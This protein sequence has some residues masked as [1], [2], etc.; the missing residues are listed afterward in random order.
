[1]DAL[2]DGA[3]HEHPHDDAGCQDQGDLPDSRPIEPETPSPPR[4][5]S[6]PT[7]KKTDRVDRITAG[8]SRWNN[9][10]IEGPPMEVA[11]PV[12]PAPN[13]ELTRV[14]GVT[15]SGPRLRRSPP[16]RGSSAARAMPICSSANRV[17]SHAPTT[18]PGIRPGRAH[19]SAR[20]S[21][22]ARSPASISPEMRSASQSGNAGTSDGT[23]SPTT[24]AVTRPMP[25]PT[26]ALDEGAHHSDEAQHEQDLPGERSQGSAAHRPTGPV[27]G[28]GDDLGH[29][30][31]RDLAGAL[32]AEVVP[33]RHVQ[34]LQTGGPRRPPA[35]RSGP[36]LGG[37]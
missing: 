6:T 34:L 31:Q 11:V 29:H 4:L 14:V 7:K 12:T 22:W 33:G 28:L 23:R 35:R 18:V 36:P 16:R 1:M 2:A 5:S 25:S 24:G 9:S 20:Q 17:T 19:A 10:A 26:T 21:M 13:P 27:V 8:A 15:V 32:P 37:G 30:R 3:T